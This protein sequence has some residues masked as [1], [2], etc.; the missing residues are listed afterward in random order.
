MTVPA[1]TE[2]RVL[3]NHGIPVDA[4]LL[5]REGRERVEEQIR[6]IV[7]S[8]RAE[9]DI[10][11]AVF[12]LLG[13]DMS[14][15]RADPELEA[16]LAAFEPGPGVAGVGSY[17]ATRE[18]FD[19]CFE[20]SWSGF[21]VA[22]ALQD[23][24]A[25]DDLVVI[26]LDDH[27]D[28]MSTLLRVDGDTLID[29][30]RAAAFHPDRP[31]DW[32]ACIHSGCIGIGSFLTALYYLDSSVHVLHLNNA[33]AGT[34]ETQSVLRE[35]C[36]YP[37]IPGQE[38]AGLRIAGQAE[39]ASLGTY[40]AGP[41]PAIVLGSP[42]SGRVVVHIDLDYFINDF[43]GNIG[44]RPAAP[45]AAQRLEAQRKM[46]AFFAALSASVAQVERW[47]VATSPGFCSIR[48]WQWLLD[49]L[50][51]RIGEFERTRRG[52]GA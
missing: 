38:F 7:R 45:P 21:F 6:R 41:D 26:H 52:D 33:A 2:S 32:E 36:T 5:R 10:G 51:E 3:V 29:P 43:N 14:Y 31:E 47:I 15:H 23:A 28:M 46:A 20:D 22:A 40:L 17:R 12:R 25:R 16:L 30:A 37:L 34:D 42:P 8:T 9:L 27:T 4:D 11:E 39:G 35:F 13:P 24:S 1:K 19:L 44:Q 18:R 48:H 49:S 50:E